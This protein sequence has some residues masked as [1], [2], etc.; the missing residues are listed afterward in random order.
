[1]VPARGGSKRVPRKNLQEVGGRSLVHHALAAALD[2]GSFADVM[3]SSDDLMRGDALAGYA[4]ILREQAIAMFDTTSGAELRRG[5]GG[6]GLGGGRRGSG[7][8][9]RSW[10][11]APV[12]RTRANSPAF[13]PLAPRTR[14]M[15]SISGASR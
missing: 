15:P 9:L 14:T 8:A 13:R 4:A 6:R 12:M 7:T 3:L 11:P 5:R 2:S 10:A 1:M